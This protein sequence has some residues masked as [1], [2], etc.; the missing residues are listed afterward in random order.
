MAKVEKVEQFEPMGDRI[1]VQPEKPKEKSGI[2]IPEAAKQETRSNRGTVVAVGAGKYDSNGEL[3]PM[4]TKVGDIVMFHPNSY[5]I[6]SNAEETYFVL[7]ESAVMI[8]I[9]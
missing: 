2:I 8:R 6:I 3:I 9:K 4:R 1:L 7:Q 5:D